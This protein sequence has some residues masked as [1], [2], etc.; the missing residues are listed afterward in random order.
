MSNHLSAYRT[1]I[2]DNGKKAE[3][4]KVL[5]D[6]GAQI[7][8]IS[9]QHPILDEAIIYSKG[10]LKVKGVFDDKFSIVNQYCELSVSYEC[11]NEIKHLNQK[12]V[13]WIIPN[14]ANFG[15]ILG[16]KSI[17]EYNITVGGKILIRRKNEIDEISDISSKNFYDYG[18]SSDGSLKKYF[19]DHKYCGKHVAVSMGEEDYLVVGNILTVPNQHELDIGKCDIWDGEIAD[20]DDVCEILT[21]QFILNVVKYNE[22]LKLPEFDINSICIGDQ[23]LPEQ[24]QRVFQ[25]LEEFK[26]IFSKGSH[27]IGRNTTLKFDFAVSSMDPQPAR[28]YRLAPEKQKLAHE[29]IKKLIK[30]S[31]L[32]R[33]PQASVITSVFI[34][35]KKPDGSIRLVSDFRSANTTILGSNIAIEKPNDILSRMANHKL[36][37]QS[38]LVKAFFGLELVENKRHLLTCV[39]PI[40]GEKWRYKKMPMGLKCSSQFFDNA[41]K[42]LLYRNI[43]NEKYCHYIAY[44]SF[45]IKYHLEQKSIKNHQCI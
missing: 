24:K 12:I 27:D 9:E 43:P 31:V 10:Q 19:I 17:Q 5:F 34:P 8:I 1:L 14:N 40:T 28:I 33:A 42:Q 4:H 20:I 44:S 39:D 38:D 29:E 7:N 21:E 22:N 36:Y 3:K 35:L 41:A 13:F 32:E 2:L 45:I 11:Q 18:F 6:T 37:I 23:L 15:V 25:L 16:L 26:D 30:A